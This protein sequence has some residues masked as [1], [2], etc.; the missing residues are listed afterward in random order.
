M[1]NLAAAA[2]MKDG[3]GASWPGA[4]AAADFL[5]V[6]CSVET[7]AA[8][9][10]LFLG[11]NKDRIPPLSGCCGASSWLVT[12]MGVALGAASL[13]LDVVVPAVDDVRTRS[14]CLI[15]VAA[16]GCGSDLVGMEP[17]TGAR[18]DDGWLEG[19]GKSSRSS[20]SSKSSKSC[21]SP[22]EPPDLSLAATELAA[23][24]SL[25]PNLLLAAIKV[26]LTVT[27]I[28]TFSF[29]LSV[30]LVSLLGTPAYSLISNVHLP[31]TRFILSPLSP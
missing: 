12:D 4:G 31:I 9:V 20:K 23:E 3:L 1:F 25:R 16:D 24:L 14:C 30:L 7:A 26:H 27:F 28:V 18:V 13:T 10:D 5:G 17:G 8:F 15:A 21:S 2:E 11:D 29:S 6:L 19:S 22:Y